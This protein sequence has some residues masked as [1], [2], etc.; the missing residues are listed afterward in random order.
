MARGKFS[1]LGTITKKERLIINDRIQCRS[2]LIFISEC[3]YAGYYGTTVPDSEEPESMFLVTDIEYDVDKVI[4]TI[5]SVKSHYQ[6]EFDAVPGTISFKNKQYGMI[7]V[8]ALPCQKIPSLI[9]AFKE[10]G[11]KFARHHKHAPF[12]GIIHVTKYF[13]TEEVE[14]GIFLD[15]ESTAYAYL[16][17]YKYIS[18]DT[19][20]NVNSYASNNIDF[21]FDAALATMY[22]EQGILDMIRIY[23]EKRTVEKLRIIQD[24]FINKIERY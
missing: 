18:W 23:D 12:D 13:K 19:F 21:S 3:P 1:S 24:K 20:E 4:R 16:R 11:I 6:H 8:R 7:R 15:L 14:E 10:K 2:A 17:I 9:N 5:Q 22:D